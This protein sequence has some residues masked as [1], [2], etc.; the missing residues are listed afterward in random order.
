MATIEEIKEKHK[1]LL[2]ILKENPELILMIPYDKAIKTIHGLGVVNESDLYIK[3][4]DLL[5]NL[6]GQKVITDL[7]KLLINH[8]TKLENG[9][10]NQPAA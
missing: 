9:T 4:A 3:T 7:A 2:D 1:E 6:H 10:T 5:V 8:E